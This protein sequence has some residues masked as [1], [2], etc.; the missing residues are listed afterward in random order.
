MPKKQI[1]KFKTEA[2]ERKFWDTH[3]TV[4]YFDAKNRVETDF[5]KLTRSKDKIRKRRSRSYS[6]FATLRDK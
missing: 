6:R 4:D 2:E 1:P 5:P 3:D